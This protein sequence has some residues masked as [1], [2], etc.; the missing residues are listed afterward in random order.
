MMML[1][2]LPL[3]LLIITIIIHS[4]RLSLIINKKEDVSLLF[5]F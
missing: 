1:F 5:F 4:I 2:T 3:S